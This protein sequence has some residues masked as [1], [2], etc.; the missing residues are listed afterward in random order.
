MAAILCQSIS[1]L[2]AGACTACSKICTAPC[3]LCSTVCQPVCEV[4]RKVCSSHFCLYVTVTLGL[5]IP[6]IIWGAQGAGSECKGSQWLTVN[7]LFCLIHLA[8]AFYLVMTT[9]SLNDTMQ[10]LCYDPW[11]AIYIVIC[12]VFFI[13]LCTGISWSS[14]GL[15]DDCPEGSTSLVSNSIYCGFAFFTIGCSALLF[16]VL[17]SFCQSRR[18]NSSSTTSSGTYKAPLSPV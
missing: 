11:I 14:K 10:V 5:N 2:F 17:L 7:I 12:F 9:T 1:N 13:W 4:T 8:A 18:Q 15:M 3:R 16:S 6:P